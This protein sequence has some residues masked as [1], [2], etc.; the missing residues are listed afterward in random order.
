[1]KILSKIF[2][3]VLII[4]LICNSN[5]SVWAH[6]NML[7]TEY[8]YCSGP[9]YN[10]GEVVPTDGEDETWYWLEWY[11][12]EYHISHNVTTIKYV[13]ADSATCGWTTY[14]SPEDAEEI[15]TAYANSMKKWN[16]IYY[17]SYDENGNRIAQKIINIEEGN[18]SDYNLI[19]YPT[20]NDEFYAMTTYQPQDDALVEINSQNVSHYHYDK[21]EMY[22]SIFYFL[23]IYDSS[24]TIKERTGEHELGHVLGLSDVDS[25]CSAKELI[26]HHEEILMGYGEGNRSTYAKYKDIA[27]VS[28]TRGFHTDSDH[29]WMLRTNDDGT[30][31][32][33]CAQCNG[34]RKNISL[35]DG[36]YEGKT[37][38]AY[39]S[40]VH[41]GGTNQKMLL[42]ATDGVRDFYKCQYCRYILQTAHTQHYY[43]GASYV[44]GDSHNKVCVICNYSNITNHDYVYT[45]INADEHHRACGTCNCSSTETHQYT[46][47]KKHTSTHH[48][49]MCKCGQTGTIISPH[50]VIQ[51][52][53]VN[54]IGF[55]KYCGARVMLGSDFGQVEPMFITK[56]TINGSYILPNG[57]IVLV[58]EDI[59]EYENGMLVWYD[60]DQL[61]QIQ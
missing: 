35:T 33:I 21:W 13:F 39:K 28:I 16:D 14:L 10:G 59:E 25:C 48:I 1:M 5:L 24:S 15:K 36:K 45:Y 3:L 17:Y 40:C 38:N 43:D 46:E 7:E 51:S 8:D 58:D 56:V 47:Y 12:R 31:D 57:I 23:D 20:L 34:V 42:V 19:I 41:H 55:C 50:V 9:V 32:V 29:V 44:D 54:N 18:L 30:M 53:V 6:R 22:V 26:D 37:V 2:V 27:G 61:P 4:V 49:N 11:G 60:K 52:E